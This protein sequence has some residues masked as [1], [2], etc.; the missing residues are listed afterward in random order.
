MELD[1]AVLKESKHRMV[2][3]GMIEKEVK[4]ERYFNTL[5]FRKCVP[6]IAPPPAKMY[7]RVRAAYTLYGNKLSSK[8]GKPLFNSTAWKKA[9]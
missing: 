3:T 7:W 4:D 2:A 5:L 8:T 9:K 1:D 6:R